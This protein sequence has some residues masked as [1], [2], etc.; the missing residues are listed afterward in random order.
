MKL[1]RHGKDILS[2]SVENI[3]P[4]GIWILVSREEYFL[5]YK[6]FP[7][8]LDKPVKSILNVKRLHYNHLYWPDIDVDLELDSIKNPQKYPLIAM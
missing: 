8:F 1:L 2:V 3:T 6:D 4:F 5:R 7:M